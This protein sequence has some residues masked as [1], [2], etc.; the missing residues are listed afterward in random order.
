MSIK[1]FYKIAGLS[2]GRIIFINNKTAS[3][4][5]VFICMSLKSII[6]SIYF[7]FLL[8]FFYSGFNNY[9]KDKK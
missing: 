7:F 1:N 3:N 6:S 2:M 8:T 4:L 5:S 9:I